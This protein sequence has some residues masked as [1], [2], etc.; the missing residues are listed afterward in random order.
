MATCDTNARNIIVG[1]GELFTAVCDTP[2]PDEE[3][4]P[5]RAVAPLDPGDSLGTMLAGLKGDAA[6]TELGYTQEGVEVSY[7]PD[8]GE[9]EVDQLK[10]A[11]LLFN[12]GV[13]VMMNTN[14]A[15]A[16]LENLLV[17]WGQPDS[18]LT[19]ATTSSTFK[20]AVPSAVPEERALAVVGRGVPR[21][22]GSAP[23]TQIETE[24][25]Y[26]ARRVVS[27][28]GSNHSL[29]RTEATVFPVSFRLLAHSD[30]P[31]SEYGTIT[32]RLVEQPPA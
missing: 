9:V 25:V 17:A 22:F 28:E 5:D 10:D 20:I 3:D 26:Y 12:Q 14:L 32:E 6:W 30:Y 1:P 27:V 2:L 13:N 24:R 15:E 31:G 19:A 8:Y 18:V 16:T 7:T 23:A 29:R 11:A 21:V 4:L